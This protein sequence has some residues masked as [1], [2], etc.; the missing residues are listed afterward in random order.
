[1][2]SSWGNPDVNAGAGQSLFDTNVPTTVVHDIDYVVA[3]LERLE[4]K[5]DAI[6]TVATAARDTAA[7]V[8]TELDAHVQY[9]QAQDRSYAQSLQ[10]ADTVIT[11]MRTVVDNIHAAVTQGGATGPA[12]P[13]Q[14][15]QPVAPNVPIPLQPVA[16]AVAAAA[17]V[18]HVSTLKL[19]K[20][21]KYDGSKKEKA[22]D[23]RLACSSYLRGAAPQASE[24]LKVEFIISYLEGAAAEWLRPYRE[25]DLT[26]QVAWLHNEA[27]FWVEF[28]RRFGEVNKV[29]TYRNKLRKLS[30]TKNVQDYLREFQTLSAPLHYDAIV[31]RDM[32]YDGLKDNIKEAMLA[33]NFDPH[34]V[35]FDE[36]TDRALQIDARL[37]AFRPSRTSTSHAAPAKSTSVTTSTTTV[38]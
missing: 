8:R 16:P 9:A 3:F 20:P 18:G 17:P 22:M 25:L 28:E 11:S 33:Q 35:T 24:T 29:D 30:Q 13:A 10:N 2:S 4:V 19:A 32:F 23:F 38:Q 37:E 6:E 12:Q 31:L 27:Q 1:M 26:T 21:D 34:A 14:P 7:L 5:I 36:L 15:A